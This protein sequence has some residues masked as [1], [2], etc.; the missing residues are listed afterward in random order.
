MRLLL[1][2]AL[3]LLMISCDSKSRKEILDHMEGPWEMVDGVGVSVTCDHKRGH[4]LYLGY[5]TLA[6]V[7]NGCAI[8]ER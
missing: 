4:L 8:K 7:P 3:A 2:V 1:L 6:V 5:G